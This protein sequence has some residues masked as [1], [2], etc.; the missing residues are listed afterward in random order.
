MFV[1]VILERM[2]VLREAQEAKGQ[3]GETNQEA[4]TGSVKTAEDELT[5]QLD[6]GEHKDTEPKE[7]ASS[8]GEPELYIQYSLF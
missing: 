8:Q 2:K 4:E 7:D 3:V 1:D 6:N 5:S